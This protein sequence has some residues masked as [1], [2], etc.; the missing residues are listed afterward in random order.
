MSDRRHER[1]HQPVI[2]ILHTKHQSQYHNC[3]LE[4]EMEE[5]NMKED[6]D[7]ELN[8]MSDGDADSEAESEPD[9]AQ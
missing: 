6:C 8:G 9:E 2:P 4:E 5:H 3:V 1:V 7:G